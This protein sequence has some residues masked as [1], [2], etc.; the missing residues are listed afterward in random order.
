MA[1]K[2]VALPAELHPE[3]RLKLPQVL[4]LTGMGKTK[5][6]ADIKVGKFPEPERDGSR[7]SRWRAGTVVNHLRQ[8]AVDAR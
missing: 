8:S 6:Y 5:L 4:A 2:P 1:T 7:W 3:Q